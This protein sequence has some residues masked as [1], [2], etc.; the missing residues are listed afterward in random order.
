M[1]KRRPIGMYNEYCSYIALTDFRTQINVA[2]VVTDPRADFRA[3]GHDTELDYAGVKPQIVT[4]QE[5]LENFGEW[6]SDVQKLIGCIQMPDKWNV[7]VVYPPL[8]S[9][10]S[11][12]IALLGD[13]VCLS[14]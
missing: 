12:R 13:A 3:A 11:G 9:Y 10:T 2:A 8:E 7:N 1:Y 6:G 14:L 5:L 4:S